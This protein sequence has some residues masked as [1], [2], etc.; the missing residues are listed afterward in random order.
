MVSH[1]LCL[2]IIF[3]FRFLYS[4]YC[5]KKLPK[6]KKNIVEENS[7]NDEEH[8][9]EN[10]EETDENY[11]YITDRSFE[12]SKL[13]SFE[14]SRLRGFCNR[15]RNFNIQLRKFNSG[16]PLITSLSRLVKKILQSVLHHFAKIDIKEQS[17]LHLSNF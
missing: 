12:A 16:Y 15:N 1:I 14:A 4:F 7:E 13:R 17:P 6:W 3:F 5:T 2:R 10:D 8:N 9:D 11:A